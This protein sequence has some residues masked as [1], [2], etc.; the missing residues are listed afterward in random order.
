MPG[1]YNAIPSVATGDWIT[2]GWVNT[3][4]GGNMTALWPY[5]A[6]GDMAYANAATEL[7]RLALGTQYKFLQAGASVPEWGGLHFA[8]VN[9]TGTQNFTSGSAAAVTF[10]AEQSDLQNWHSTVSN[11]SRI[12]VTATGRYMASATLEYAAAGGTGTYW[13]TVE[14]RVNGST[15][16]AMDRRRQ[17]IDAF[18]KKFSI[19]SPVV[20]MGTGEYVEVWLEQNAGGTYAVQSGAFF[21]LLRVG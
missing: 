21:S 18:N 2:A 13:D 12:T 16:I 10:D 20:G 9:K 15:V 14:L 19:S 4:V 1:T 3:Y 7:A 11:T 6:I 17:N 5:T 8:T